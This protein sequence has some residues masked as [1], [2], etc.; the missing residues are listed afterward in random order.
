MEGRINLAILAIQQGSIK[1]IR[2]ASI[3]YDIPWSTLNRRVKGCPARRDTRPASSKLTKT[4]ESTLVKWILSMDQRGLAPTYDIVGQMANLLLQKRSQTQA[5]PPPTIGQNWV[6]NLV[7]R[8]KALKY[9]YNRKYDY[10]R[11][12]CE[13]PAI[14]QPWFQLVRNTIEKYSILDADIYNF[15]ETGFQ[16]GVIS[17]AKVITG[18]ERS[19]RPVSVQPGNREWVTAIDCIYADGQSLPPVIIFEGKMHQS[20]WYTDNEL[21]RDWVIGVSENGWTDNELGLTWL[22]NVFEK[23]TAP[24]TKGVYRLLILDG[25][26]SHLTPEFDLF[27]TEHSIITLCIPPHSSHLLQ[28]CDV[29]LFAVLKRQYGQQI[30]GYIRRGTHHID[31]QDF[32]QAYL[33]ART[34]AATTANIQSSFAATGLVL[35]DPERVLSKLCTQLKTPTPPSSSY[36]QAPQPW[37]FQTPHNTTQLELQAKA[38]QDNAALPTPENRALNQLVKGCQLA[39]Q[40]AVLLAEEVRQLRHEAKRQKRKKAKKRTFIAKGGVLTIQEGRDLSQNATREV[41]GRVLYQEVAVRTRALPK[42]SIC[43]SLEHNA[44]TCP[45]R[46]VSN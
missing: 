19:R 29:S 20:T 5:N 13:D 32:L 15:D 36:A 8:H 43:K 33:I 38:I 16:I 26:G 14:I 10:Q 12:K 41:E 28:P 3:A 17:T 24:R 27:C 44:R 31:K 40:S 30:Q 35:H 6:Y 46:Q 4:E 42:C 21:P 39:M 23:H 34:E 2:A 25:H 7:K 22:K 37:Q 9:Q 45:I 1:S 18:A 11:A